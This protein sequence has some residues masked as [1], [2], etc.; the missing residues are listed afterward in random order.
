MRVLVILGHPR[1]RSLCGA[2]ARAFADGARGAGADVRQIALGDLRFDPDVRAPSPRDQAL[3]DDLAR[4]QA[5]I[6]WADHLVFVFP[7]W[8]GA[9]PARLKGFLDRVLT[10]GFAFAEREGGGYEALLRG[11]S[12]HLWTTMDTPPWVYRAVYRAPGVR[13]LAAATLGF[14]GVWP[15]RVDLIGPVKGASAARRERWVARASAS[16]ARLGGGVLTAG[17][18]LRQRC[19]A[20]LCALRLQFYPM[21]WVAYTVGALAAHPEG[22]FRRPAYWLGWLCLFLIEAATVLTNELFDYTTD[23]RNA[24]YGPFTGGSRVLPSG[25]LRFADLRRGIRNVLAVAACAVSA[26]SALVPEPG[27][28]CALVG[29]GLA[30]GL[31]YTAPPLRLSYRGLGEG[32]VGVTHGLLTTLCGYVFLGGAWRDPLPWTLG[33]AL[34][35]SLLPA[36]LLAGFPDAEA[37][38]AVGKKT[39]TVR[40]GRR[41]AASLAMALTGLSVAVVLADSPHASL[42]RGAAWVLVPHGL[43]LMAMLH[44][45]R[46]RP[47]RAG[48]IDALLATALA[49][50]AAFG[51][52]L[53]TNLLRRGGPVG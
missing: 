10:P 38:A 33:I 35:L 40:L 43:L 12:A 42:W 21:A 5:A 28:A 1:G 7:T 18:R 20:W 34:G 2:L 45:H 46:S 52:I 15:V 25:R 53:L 30:L 9:M 41:R 19:G 17:E 36:I 3:E 39:Q 22:L 4:A 29:L 32:T 47:E 13:A 51:A 50:H 16:G 49:F 26:L 23:R 44:R 14:C 8:W 6:A 48:R 11:K 27:A 31:G 24:H 37:D